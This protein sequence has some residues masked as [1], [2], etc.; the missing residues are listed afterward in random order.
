M[1]KLKPQIQYWED[2]KA[3]IDSLPYAELLKLNTEI[4]NAL[5][6]KVVEEKEHLWF[7]MSTAEMEG[8]KKYS[9]EI[10]IG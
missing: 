4:K 8:N 3:L 9:K 1:E 5:D 6:Y 10:F 2:K 7:H